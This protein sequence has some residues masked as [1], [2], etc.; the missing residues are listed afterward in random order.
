MKYYISSVIFS[1]INV[2][3]SIA[4][5]NAARLEN[6]DVNFEFKTTATFAESVLKEVL[7]LPREKYFDR[8]T[9]E[10][11]RQR[12]KKFYFDNGFFDVL[13]DTATEIS[14]DSTEIDLEFKIVENE[15]YFIKEIHYEGIGLISEE[16]KQEIYPNTLIKIGDPYIKQNIS[17]E[18]DRVINALQ[19]TGYYRAYIAD[20]LGTIVAKYSDELQKKQEYR[21]KVV[22]RFY[23]K[24]AQDRYR[25]G[26]TK[27]NIIDNRYNLGKDIIERELEFKESELFNRGKMQESEYNLTKIALIQIGRVEVDTVF[28]ED[29]KVQ[30]KVNITLGKKYEVT[31]G[32]S[33]I[34]FL[35]LLYGGASLKYQDKNFFGGGRIFSA[36]IEGK[37]HDFGNN[38]VELSFAFTQPYLFNNNI[39]FTLNPSI[40]LLNWNNTREVV[41]FNNLA[42]L[43]YF[44]APYTFYQNAY[45][46]LT[47]DQVRTRYK[48]DYTDDDGV[49]H[50]EGS[51]TSSMNSIIGATI[52]HNSTNDLFSPSKGGYNSITFESAGLVPRLISLIVKDVEY[53]Q[54]IKFYIPSKFFKDVSGTASAII[55]MN[56][57]IGDIIEYGAGK[58]IVPI[59]PIYKFFSGGGNSIR[60]WRGQENGILNVKQDGGKFLLE[61]SMEYR[62]NPLS[63]SK[64]FLKNFW[65]VGFFDYGNV[66]EREKYFRFSQIALATGLGLRYNTFVGPIRIDLGFKLFDPSADEGKRWL[67]DN[68]S[69]IFKNKYA[70]HFG[71]GN[72]F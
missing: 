40:G 54:Y 72:A 70:V 30:M 4:G 45:F 3:V 43:S 10:D 8:M 28:E 9:F 41:Y 61:G 33:V 51:R 68:P 20:T 39:S 46:D 35:N 29:H 60:G 66:W 21:H 38:Q 48:R 15:R 37:I 55:A 47:L 6:G 63:D 18:K 49:F 24:G 22:I 34:Y 53:S 2:S 58:N 32:I 26:N 64:N 27:I 42:R 7:L 5:I 71:L 69:D 1:L 62:W 59:N 17:L 16:A 31:P 56:L 44:I 11:D 50:P 23:F 13:V 14:D 52:I 65:V 57:E 12:L 19:N 67:W 25:F 36:K